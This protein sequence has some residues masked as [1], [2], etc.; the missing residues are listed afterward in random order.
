MI[1]TC[2]SPLQHSSM[3]GMNPGHT[4]SVLIFLCWDVEKHSK[5]ILVFN[6]YLVTV[7]FLANNLQ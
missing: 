5:H 4:S 1:F 7:Y 6:I 3:T 2:S